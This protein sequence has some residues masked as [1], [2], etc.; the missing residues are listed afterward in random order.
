MRSETGGALLQ[1]IQ[2]WPEVAGQVDSRKWVKGGKKLNKK[3]ENLDNH[4]C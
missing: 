1:Y 3:T 4:D 2:G